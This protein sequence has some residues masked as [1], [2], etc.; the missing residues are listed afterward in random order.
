MVP[1][2]EKKML[3]KFPGQCRK[4]KRKIHVG[5]LIIFAR[6]PNGEGD[7]WHDPDKGCPVES[8]LSFGPEPR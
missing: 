6:W 8:T 7:A 4:C 5:E 2:Y 3:A 1:Y